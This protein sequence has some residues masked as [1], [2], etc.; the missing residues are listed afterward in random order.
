MVGANSG[1]RTLNAL[2]GRED[3]QTFVS[4]RT[5]PSGHDCGASLSPRRSGSRISPFLALEARRYSVA[6]TL[7]TALRSLIVSS[8]AAALPHRRTGSG[9]HPATRALPNDS[10]IPS[11]RASSIGQRAPLTE[12]NASCKYSI[13]NVTFITWKSK[14]VALRRRFVSPGGVL[15]P[16]T[17]VGHAACESRL[18]ESTSDYIGRHVDD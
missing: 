18:R 1:P 12:R 7:V 8:I 5:S 11:T 17:G 14:M 4:D 3:V 16:P 6:R 9:R 13:V 15:L 10:S 2:D